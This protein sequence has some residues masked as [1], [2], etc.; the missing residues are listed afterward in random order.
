MTTPQLTKRQSYWLDHYKR[1]KKQEIPFEIYCRKN[2]LSAGA[3]GHARRV[4]TERGAITPKKS[5]ESTKTP[6][7]L[8]YHL[9]LE[10]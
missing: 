6:G 1:R 3:F 5:N 2:N 10:T 4:L 9:L 7:P 8:R